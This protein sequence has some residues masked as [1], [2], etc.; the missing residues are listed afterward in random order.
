LIVEGQGDGSALPVLL[1]MFF[2]EEGH[3]RIALGTPIVAKGRTKL[4]KEGELERFV[5]LAGQV[6]GACGVLVV[7]DANGDPACELGPAC[8]ARAR[9]ATHLPVRVCL[10]VRE[11][12]NWIVASAETVFEMEELP[13]E[14]AEG[15]GALQV[16]KEIRAPQKYVKTLHQAGLASSID[17]SLARGRAP[18]LDR[19]L[20]Y[21]EELVTECGA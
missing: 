5:T 19:L 18:S 11:F 17:L 1:R 10:A 9:A 2:G 8:L 6:P 13:L 12:E 20:R 7:F 14:S 16:I 3:H 15:I 4:L 21:A